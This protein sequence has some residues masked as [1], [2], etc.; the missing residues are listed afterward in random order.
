MPQRPPSFAM[1][2]AM[3][4]PPSPRSRIDQACARR[5]SYAFARDCAALLRGDD[6][7]PRLVSELG[8]PG[9]AVFLDGSQR[10]DAYWL[11]VWAA[12]GLLWADPDA[13]RGALA[14]VAAALDDESWRVREMAL[15]VIA[16]Q[17]WGE[18]LEQAASLADDPVPRVRA[19]AARTVQVL[20]LAGD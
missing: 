18:L 14:T 20:T 16:R 3:S 6:V 12:R 8:G 10:E 5:G 15:K 9:A 13:A 2:T 11:R 7:D 19:A 17:H 1:L 4:S